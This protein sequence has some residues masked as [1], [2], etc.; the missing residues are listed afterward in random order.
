MA[1]D[2]RLWYSCSV[3]PTSLTFEARCSANSNTYQVGSIPGGQT[4]I[5]WDPY[6][7]V[8]HRPSARSSAFLQTSQLTPSACL[9]SCSYAQS[10]G[11][12]ALAQAS[13]TLRVADERGYDAAATAGY[14]Y[15]QNAMV[16]FA[17]YSPAAYVSLA[18]GECCSCR[19]RQQDGGSRGWGLCCRVAMLCLLVRVDAGGCD[20]EPADCGDSVDDGGDADRRG[21]RVQ[22]LNRPCWDSVD[23]VACRCTHPAISTVPAH[24]QHRVYFPRPPFWTPDTPPAIDTSS[25]H[26]SLLLRS[27]R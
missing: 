4:T 8:G 7:S 16:N 11:A 25:Y 5:V 26:Q 21:W 14:F 24:G 2:N 9:P 23:Y 13:Y 10:A 19:C 12:V 15:G 1:T 3:T 20:D 18:D 22:L 17:L 6:A 27:P